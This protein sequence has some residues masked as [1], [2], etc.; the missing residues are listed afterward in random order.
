MEQAFL[1]ETGQRGSV[2][3]I[4][5]SPSR[6][7][8]N[9]RRPRLAAAYR[10]CFGYTPVN[11]LVPATSLFW[12]VHKSRVYD[13]KSGPGWYENL[14]GVVSCPESS[15]INTDGL[16]SIVIGCNELFLRVIYVALMKIV[17]P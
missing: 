5:G 6:Q 7:T 10:V 1:F 11:R 3:A 9:R 17:I 15:N 4:S 16:D 8:P 2:R 14:S 13:C 12:A